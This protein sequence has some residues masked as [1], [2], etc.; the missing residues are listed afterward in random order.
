[1]HV[2]VETTE[3]MQPEEENS[4]RVVKSFLHM[5]NFSRLGSDKLLFT[6]IEA[7]TDRK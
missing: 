6:P 4:W 5:H 1:M 2:K 7:R 3:T